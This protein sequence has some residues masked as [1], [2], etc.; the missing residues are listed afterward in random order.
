MIEN[1]CENNIL[2]IK[3]HGHVDSSNAAQVEADI[4]AL[5]ALYPCADIVIDAENLSYISSAG[6]RVVLKLRKKCAGLKIINASASVY[7]VLEM[8]GFTDMMTV[9]KAFR[10]VSVENCEIIGR[11]ANGVV[12]RLDD[13]T[14]VKTYFDAGALNDMQHDR[15]I[16]RRV[17]VLGVPTAI[18]YD[19]VKVGDAYGAV[20]EMLNARSLSGLLAENP[21][22][23]DKYAQSYVELL[24]KIHATAVQP[25]DMPDIRIAALEWAD[26]VKQYL[27]EKQFN[28]L[29]S[30]IK[31]VGEHNYMIH[32]DYHTNNVMMQNDEPM[33]IDLDNVAVGH[34][35]FEWAAIYMGFV[36]FCELDS[37][38]TQ[39][40]LG[41]PRQTA[42]SFYRKAL[43]IYM[44]TEDAEVLRD[45]EQKA[46]VICFMRLMRRAVRHTGLDT[47]RGQRE[48]SICRK[49]LDYLLECVDT[50]TF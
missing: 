29:H 25:G 44:N 11:G 40:F 8:T 36:G 42:M 6:L 12:Y 13:E 18:P 10:R 9:M 23:I 24:R 1:T 48:M 21:D 27:P 43:A 41:I 15:E 3:P 19:V 50:L 31:A 26:F 45:V 38:A 20:Y 32:G 5:T 4:S 46:Q 35:V 39:R 7:E 34:P 16:A 2:T 22:N 37:E 33:L 47:D 28:K 30:M 49:K 14:I 17:F